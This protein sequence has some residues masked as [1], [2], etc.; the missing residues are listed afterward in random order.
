MNLLKE[1]H[2]LLGN[3]TGIPNGMLENVLCKY[4]LP[5]REMRVFFAL[6]RKTW[7]WRKQDE[8][9]TQRELCKLTNISPGNISKTIKSMVD[10]YIIITRNGKN[11][12]YFEINR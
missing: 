11:K 1:L 10:K 9:M 12:T 7:G 2:D 3:F 8:Y 5:Q 4:N 6:A